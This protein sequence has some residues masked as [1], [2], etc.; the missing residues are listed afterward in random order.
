[1]TPPP[2]SAFTTSTTTTFTTTTTTTFIGYR[3]GGVEVRSHQGIT[4]SKI[5]GGKIT[6][7]HWSDQIEKTVVVVV[8]VV[9]V[10]VGEGVGWEKG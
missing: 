1:M 6:G 7:V 3:H 5:K 4:E 9:V 8:V 2:L 10:M